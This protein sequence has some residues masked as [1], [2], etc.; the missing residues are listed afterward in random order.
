MSDVD[1]ATVQL[2]DLV[3]PH[4]RG[5]PL[6]LIPR[7]AYMLVSCDVIS[8]RDRKTGTEKPLYGQIEHERLHS[9]GGIVITP[10]LVVVLDF[11][12]ELDEL[13]SVV[14]AVKGEGEFAD[15]DEL[16]LD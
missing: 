8:A 11:E 6:Y 14:N 13:I 2:S 4:E 15:D 16:D 3:A 5:G 10:P 12:T 9:L 1:S 7:R